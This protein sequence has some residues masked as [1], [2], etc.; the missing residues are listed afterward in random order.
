MAQRYKIFGERNSGTNLIRSL[1]SE[2][3]NLVPDDFFTPRSDL[4][5]QLFIA[6]ARRFPQAFFGRRPRAFEDLL[7]LFTARKHDAIFGWKHSIPDIGLLKNKKI[8][9]I[10]VTKHPIYWSRS[11][12]EKPFDSYSSQRYA[13]R[14]HV[15]I[16]RRIEN[17]ERI[18]IGREEL[19]M[20]KFRAYK[21]TLQECGGIHV[22]YETLI[23]Y[24]DECQK[25]FQ[26]LVGG[27]ANL[28]N[29]EARVFIKTASTSFTS[30]YPLEIDPSLENY[31]SESKLIAHA[32]LLSSFGY[33]PLKCM[34]TLPSSWNAASPFGE[35]SPVL[36]DL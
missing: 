22:Q 19:I 4:L 24:F 18:P 16:P 27:C 36:K 33:T 34:K 28:P 20:A 31:F 32:N 2:H 14:S 30:K 8:I 3:I 1:L 17:M 29:E 11:F 10:I 13:P 6:Y 5:R 9:P 7:D 35:K 12:H 23:H 25:S 15:Y 21:N 26:Y